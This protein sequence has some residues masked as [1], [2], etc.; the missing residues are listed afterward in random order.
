[1]LLIIAA[2]TL[3][4]ARRRAPQFM[5]RPIAAVMPADGRERAVLRVVRL[6]GGPVKAGEIIAQAI[7]GQSGDDV[8]SARIVQA[9]NEVEVWMRSPVMAGE[10][11]VRVRWGRRTL[12]G[13]V[14][15]ATSE[16]DSFG[17]G[18]LDAL[19]LHSGE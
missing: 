12:V 4:L 1:M 11:Q 13:T 2:G 19:R 16:V 3:L 17:D 5:V 18:T 7:E 8:D 14:R 10:R 15:F 6:D 9:G